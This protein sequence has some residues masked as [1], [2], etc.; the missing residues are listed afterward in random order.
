MCHFATNDVMY[1]V[2]RDLGIRAVVVAVGSAKV[3]TI[4][5]EDDLQDLAVGRRVWRHFLCLP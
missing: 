3:E 5:A 2:I 1:S 4:V